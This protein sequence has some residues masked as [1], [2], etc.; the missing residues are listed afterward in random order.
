MPDWSCGRPARPRGA[1]LRLIV[2]SGL[3]RISGSVSRR[4][5]G[6]SALAL[7]FAVALAGCAA[8]T[9]GGPSPGTPL[10]QAPEGTVP[11]EPPVVPPAAGETGGVKVALILPLSAQGN[12]GLVAQSMRN[13]AELALAEFNNPNVQL[14]I[15]D[16]RGSPAQARQ[17]ATQA[18]DE[19]AEII[20]GSLFAQTVQGIGS[21]ARPRGI[22]V[23]AF[24]T[25][26][27]IAARGVYL[28]SF[29]P[30]SDVVRVIGYTFSTGKRS[31]AGL[32][33]ENAYGSVVEASFREDVA[34][35]GGRIVGLERY[36]ADKGKQAEAVRSIAKVAQSAD[37]I[38]IPDGPDTAPNVVL[39]L[40][41]AGVSNRAQLI[42]T[43]LWEDQRVFQDNNMQGAIYAAPDPA[44]FANF[45]QRYRAK[46]GSDPVRTATLSYDATALVAALVRTQGPQRFSEEVLT[47]QSGFAG[48]DGI[49]RFKPD[50]TNERGLA[51]MRVTPSGGQIVSPTP[52]SFTG[53]SGM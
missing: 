36:S 37:A 2:V 14:I 19:G 24:S 51:V 10:G 39:A 52:R 6:R 46:F 26:A 34:R 8:Q 49:F 15:K 3:L 1:V 25:D 21:V 41:N 17:V 32:I 12:A 43:G 42:G 45:S 11:G 31:F 7:V 27:S 33:P 44:G 23:I 40:R 50:G 35:R 5:F 16:D 9:I 13:A 18:I 4:R 48:I 22:P 29:L 30:E 47:N 38:F 20:I 53:V 28:L